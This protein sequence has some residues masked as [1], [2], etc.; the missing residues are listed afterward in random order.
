[1]VVKREDLNIVPDELPKL[2]MQLFSCDCAQRNNPSTHMFYVFRDRLDQKRLQEAFTRVVSK[3]PEIAGRIRTGPPELEIYFSGPVGCPFRIRPLDADTEDEIEGLTS[4]E[5]VRR[6]L[7]VQELLSRRAGVA[8]VGISNEDIIDREGPLCVV[9]CCYGARISVLAM[10]LCHLVGD[11]FTFFELL[12]CWEEEYSGI[13][14]APLDRRI[15]FPVSDFVLA[16]V[17][18]IVPVV[19]SFFSWVLSGRPPYAAVVVS[20]T[21]SQLADFK[22][23]EAEKVPAGSFISSN[24]AFVA[25]LAN[26]FNSK[27]V[28]LSADDRGRGMTPKRCSGNAFFCPLSVPDSSTGRWS[29]LDIRRVV[30]SRR[31]DNDKLTWR[32]SG[33]IRREDICSISNWTKVQHVPSFGSEVLFCGVGDI[34]WFNYVLPFATLQR[35]RPGEIVA[36]HSG[37]QG[38]Q[39][40]RLEAAYK[41]VGV[42]SLTVLSP[43]A[44]H[45]AEAALRRPVLQRLAVANGKIGS[46]RAVKETVVLLSGGHTGIVPLAGSISV[47]FLLSMLWWQWH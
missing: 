41:E 39:V 6:A 28:V 40:A 8:S 30:S 14:S 20:M 19:L 45:T 25:W 32:R 23:R 9:T 13:A 46:L 35:A 12:R 38:S 26:T 18:K 33:V 3:N 10:S 22:A 2:P 16:N 7:A 17:L 47:V 36:I 15:D 5:Y 27:M 29:P 4:E 31:S 1:M 44:I 24:D 43:E 34:N 42:S 21:E 11:A 37:L